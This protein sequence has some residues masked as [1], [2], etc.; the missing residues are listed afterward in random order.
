MTLPSYNHFIGTKAVRIP[1]EIYHDIMAL[2]KTLDIYKGRKEEEPDA[3][4]PSEIIQGLIK[5]VSDLN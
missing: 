2:V 5:E 1:V 4:P 3:L